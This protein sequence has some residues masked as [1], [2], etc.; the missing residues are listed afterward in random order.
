MRYSIRTRPTGHA[1]PPMRATRVILALTALTACT[2]SEP[3][4]EPPGTTPS[5]TIVGGS[6]LNDTVVAA[7]ARTLT[8]LVR[9]SAG[10]AAG[11]IGVTLTATTLFTRSG[12]EGAIVA[13]L[14]NGTPPGTPP[15]V[16]AYTDTTDAQGRLSVTVFMGGIAGSG[17]IVVTAPAIGLNDTV[18]VTVRAGRTVTV[19]VEPLDT[20]VYVGASYRLRT[21]ALDRFGNARDTV[22]Q[23]SGATGGIALSGDGR[24]TGTAIG[25]SRLIATAGP[26]TDTAFVSVVPTGAIAAHETPSTLTGSFRV[27]TVNLDGSGYRVVATESP[28][29][30]G[31]GS[32]LGGHSMRP[33]WDRLGRT[34]V[35]QDVSGEALTTST[36]SAITRLFITDLTAAPRRLLAPSFLNS[37][38][39][40]VFA[41]D[42]ATVYFRGTRG[43]FSSRIW[44]V[45]TDGTGLAV[46]SPELG[47]IGSDH[48][49]ISPD[50][51]EL[52]YSSGT[53]IR[54]RTLATGAERVLPVTG[55]APHWSP[56][57]SLIAYVNTMNDAFPGELRLVRADGTADRAV[58][59]D[60]PASFDPV[61]DWS[62]DGRFII[63][64]RLEY[65]RLDLVSVASG[66]RIP[67]PYAVNLSA[68]AW[69]PGSST[70]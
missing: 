38:R 33:A 50:G 67:L 31:S 13:M 22:A 5:V 52:A 42:G 29:T 8:L 55:R 10:A 56:D 57:G 36:D 11:R 40:A 35:F 64:A 15:L 4:T 49:A 14:R 28:G 58:V 30:P 7:P 21:L 66:Q 3:P 70:P 2:S 25:R 20:A 18:P 51:T 45:N 53:T 43:G 63:V 69:R 54:I 37:Q 27:V 24:V 39:D 44:R 47:S 60:G 41:A 61:M 34:L 48:P 12:L 59:T 1:A 16:A 65:G 26:F 9:T 23:F 19:V 62:P 68:P 46:V 6:A 32:I 17:G